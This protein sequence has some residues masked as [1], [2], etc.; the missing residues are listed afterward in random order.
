MDFSK[1]LS[2]NVIFK[3]MKVLITGASFLYLYNYLS[4][5]YVRG[6]INIKFGIQGFIFILLF[7]FSNILLSIAW[8]KNIREIFGLNE[9]ESFLVS[10]RSYIGKYAAIKIGSYVIKYSQDFKLF[11]KK[12]FV[13]LAFFEQLVSLIVGLTFGIFYLFKNLENTFLPLILIFLIN[14]L[15]FFALKYSVSK[16]NNLF[17]KIVNNIVLYMLNSFYLFF[18]ISEYIKTYNVDKYLLIAAFYIFVSS[19]SMIFSIMPA[20]LGVKEAGLIFLLT[21][22]IQE[23]EII[24]L[25]IELRILFII[26]DIFSYLLGLLERL[27]KDK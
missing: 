18:I 4:D 15:L 11:D 22:I 14:L 19:L 23:Q 12:Q 13:K 9:V 24:N 25:L 7:V 17:S 5:A 8:S 10:M 27:K 20:G 6:T 16:R 21:G 26:S 1:I 3:I 2:E